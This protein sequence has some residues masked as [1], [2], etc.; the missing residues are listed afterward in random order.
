MWCVACGSKRVGSTRHALRVSK[1]AEYLDFDLAAESV[2]I[3]AD[4]VLANSA[5]QAVSLRFLHRGNV[6]FENCTEGFCEDTLYTPL[7]RHFVGLEEE[8][9]IPGAATI[10]LRP[11]HPVPH[12]DAF[13]PFSL[14]ETGEF[15]PRQLAVFRVAGTLSG[16]SYRRLVYGPTYNEGEAK[17][18]RSPIRVYGGD[19]LMGAI[20]RE[21]LGEIRGTSG[22]GARAVYDRALFR[23]LFD[24]FRADYMDCPDSYHVLL[25]TRTRDGRHLKVLPLT[26]DLRGPGE[27][28]FD[29][30][31][32]SYYWSKSSVFAIEGKVNGLQMILEPASGLQ[33]A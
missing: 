15:E 13:A 21:D 29:E 30:R 17:P 1:V 25:P 27:Q 8:V 19:V 16:P 31:L 10:P 7:F 3:A 9:A 11:L 2:G 28:S 20:E 18:A 5:D 32:V 24:E 26:P 14:Y 22:R 23:T 33:R 12:G 6:S 4:F